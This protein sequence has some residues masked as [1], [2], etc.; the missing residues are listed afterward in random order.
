ML[1]KDKWNDHIIRNSGNKETWKF[2]R[3]IV[4]FKVRWIFWHFYKFKLLKLTKQWTF[5]FSINSKSVHQ[6]IRNL[7]IPLERRPVFFL[8]VYRGDSSPP[9]QVVNKE[10][11]SLRICARKYEP[12]AGSSE[13]KM[14]GNRDREDLPEKKN[15][16]EE[17]CRKIFVIL[18]TSWKIC[19]SFAL[20]IQ[21]L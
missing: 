1:G 20:T 8:L 14:D 19:W 12:K 4:F 7:E 5:F 11:R 10:P 13:P 18:T 15:R 16:N 3:Y 9:K 17:K 6:T 2:P 21:R